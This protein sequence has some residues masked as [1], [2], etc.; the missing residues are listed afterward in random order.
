MGA[1]SRGRLMDW[2]DDVTYAVHDLED[3]Y[4]VGLIPLDRLAGRDERSRFYDS[5]FQDGSAARVLRS[6]FAAF[7]KE[8]IAE[9]I[10]F[11]FDQAFVD[12]PPYRGSRAERA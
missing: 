11:L 3:F 1:N 12:V 5:F 8:E 6:K 4:R 2:A 10:A 7:T 9:A